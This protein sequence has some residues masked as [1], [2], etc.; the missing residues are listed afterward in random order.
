MK[1]SAKKEANEEG[2]VPESFTT[3]KINQSDTSENILRAL[4]GSVEPMLGTVT[5]LEK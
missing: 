3:L 1:A 5:T 4:N 2:V